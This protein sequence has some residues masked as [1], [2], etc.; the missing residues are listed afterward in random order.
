MTSVESHTVAF[1]RAKNAKTVTVPA[2]I[3]IG[4]ATYKVAGIKAKAFAGSKATNLIVKSKKLTKKSVKNSLKGSKIRT[5]QVK[6]GTTKQ[7]K[8]YVIKYKKI[9]TKANAGKKVLL[10]AC[11][12]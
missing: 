4:E 2:S 1:T 5:V 12:G 6:V 9:F 7:N 8:K 10:R 11:K 3:M